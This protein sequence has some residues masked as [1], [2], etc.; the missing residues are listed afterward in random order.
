[1]HIVLGFLTTLVTVLY[2]LD[3]MGV[4]LAGLNP[5]SWRRRRNWRNKFEGDPLFAVDDPMEAAA[6][7]VVGAAKIDGDF[8]ADQKIAAITQFEKKFS[9]EPRAASELFGSAAH[10][11]GGP[12]LIGTQ[13]EKFSE[14]H[15]ET[16]SREQAQSLIDMIEQLAAADGE[17]TD[18]QQHFIMELRSK[19]LKTEPATGVW[20]AGQ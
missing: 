20:S 14:R 8:S 11:L 9:L 17:P 5:W 13:L 16:F 10:L 15:V 3:R 18:K 7:L 12:Q 1:M 6:I 2:L 19:I 4:D